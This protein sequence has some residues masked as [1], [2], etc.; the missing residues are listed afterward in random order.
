MKTLKESILSDMEDILNN[1]EENIKE[2]IQN[3]LKQNYKSVYK[4]EISEK[5]FMGKYRVS[6]KGISVKN[7]DIEY[8]TNDLF[9]F[10]DVKIFFDCR[11]CKNLKSLKG[12]PT[13]LNG[14][15]NIS[16]CYNL[17]SLEYI[18]KVVAGDII[19]SKNYNKKFTEDDIKKYVKKCWSIGFF[20]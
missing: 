5:H 9:E 1:G 4:F 7:K 18:P 16:G 3:F 13:K 8:L 14:S 2:V 12:L 10:D 6:G 17:E 19:L 11:D 20:N 15:L